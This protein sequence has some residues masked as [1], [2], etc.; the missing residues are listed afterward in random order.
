[1]SAVNGIR[2]R[3][4]PRTRILTMSQSCYQWEYPV[5]IE[6]HLSRLLKAAPVILCFITGGVGAETVV[7]PITRRDEL[8]IQFERLKEEAAGRLSLMEE[9]KRSEALDRKSTRL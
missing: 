7:D 8:T 5:S 1:M 3:T 9:T 2:K 6:R 4:A